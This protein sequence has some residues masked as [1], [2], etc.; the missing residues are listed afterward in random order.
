MSGLYVADFAGAEGLGSCA[1]YIGH[2]LIVGVDV[3]RAVYRGAYKTDAGRLQGTVTLTSSVP[4][5][6][7]VT[8]D[9]LNPGQLLPIA[10][11][12]P[13]P[14]ADGK[15]HT[16]SVAGKGVTVRFEKIGDLP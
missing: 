5:S 11:D 9:I 13:I 10:I 4:G 2:G 14:F 16:V 6:D 8:G 12:L 15:A 1:L 3:G 7:L